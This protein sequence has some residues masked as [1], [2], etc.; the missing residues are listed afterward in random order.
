[1][2]T[3]CC[4]LLTACCLLLSCCRQANTYNAFTKEKDFYYK[5]VSVGDEAKKIKAPEALC[6]EISCK[7]LKD[8]VFWD[9]KHAVH[10]NFYVTKE[11]AT[12]LKHLFNFSPGDSLI[13][14]FPAKKFFAGFFH[15]GIP[16]FSQKDSA[17]RVEAK[18]LASL[19]KTAFARIADSLQQSDELQKEKEAVEIKQYVSAHCK[20][21]KEFASN[22][23]IEVLSPS[24]GDS[25]KPGDHIKI[26]YEG[27]FLDGKEVDH[28]PKGKYFEFTCGQEAQVLDGIQLA[29]YRLKKGEK[30]KIILPSQLAFGRE[31]S[32]NGAVPSY[33]PLVYEIEIINK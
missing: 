18:I 15:S 28:S 22:A 19:D 12:E 7:T 30:A 1:M 9:T 27:S 2:K 10:G 24:A 26:I 20:T 14:F 4:L 17:V 16:F 6:V 5:L 3:A 25:V 13:Y 32:S 29:I 11:S 8:S 23:F 31:G 21:V 33:T